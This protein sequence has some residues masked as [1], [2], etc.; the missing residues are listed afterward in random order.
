VEQGSARDVFASP[1]HPY[2]R[3]LMDSMPR[4]TGG[5]ER[6]AAIAGLPPS[7]LRV[8]P[9]CPFAPRCPR[10]EDVC[11]HDPVPPTIRIG[12]YRTSACH[13][14]EAVIADARR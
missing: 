6:L 1:A 9:G 12:P 3:A 13:F 7:L 5:G 14:A 4:L 2:T 8:P 10:A 11:R